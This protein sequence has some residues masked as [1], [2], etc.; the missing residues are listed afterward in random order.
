MLLNAECS[1]RR[2]KGHHQMPNSSLRSPVHPGAAMIYPVTF[3]DEVIGEIGVG[4]G[5]VVLRWGMPPEGQW[6]FYVVT[7]SR[8]ASFR[9][10]AAAR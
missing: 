5:R 8:P 6:L 9:D 2:L 1:F 7:L 10:S 3:C 4:F